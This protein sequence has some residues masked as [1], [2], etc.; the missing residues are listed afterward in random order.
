MMNNNCHEY[1]LVIES[2]FLRCNKPFHF[3]RLVSLNSY[4]FCSKWLT[5]VML[6]AKDL[7]KV[8]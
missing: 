7:I 1:D 3:C 8:K 6:I 4:I 5:Q 2:L